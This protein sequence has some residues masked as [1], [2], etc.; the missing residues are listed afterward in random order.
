MGVSEATIWN[1]ERHESS[2]RIHVLPW[3]IRFLGYNPLAAPESLAG[4]QGLQFAACAGKV[5]ELAKEKKVGR[6][7]PTEW[8]LQDIRD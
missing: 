8:F 2:P 7:L 1:W 4:T 6:E 3:V 5:V